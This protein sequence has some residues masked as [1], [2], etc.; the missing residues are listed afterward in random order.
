MRLTVKRLISLLL[1]LCLLVPVGT[2][3]AAEEFHLTYQ[4]DHGEI[5]VTGYVGSVPATLE[6]P[7][8]IEGFPVTAIALYAFEGCGSLNKVVLPA[9]LKRIEDGAFYDCSNLTRIILPESLSELGGLVFYGCSKLAVTVYDNGR[10]L[11]TAANP[12]YALINIVDPSVEEMTVHGDACLVSDSAF[13]FATS[14]KTIHV[15]EDSAHFSADDRGV[16]LNKDQT[17]VL[18]APQGLTGSYTLPE[19]VTAIGS[20]AFAGCVGL[21]QIHTGN[22]LTEI[23]A[24]A[25]GECAALELVEMGDRLQTIGQEAFYGCGALKELS[26][27]ASLEHLGKDAFLECGSL[28]YYLYSGGLY[29]GNDSNPYHVL[30]KAVDKEITSFTVHPA[31]KIIAPCAFFAC[32][33]LGKITVPQGVVTIG[34][35]AFDDCYALTRVTLPDSLRTVGRRAFSWCLKLKS[36]ELPS[37]VTALGEEAFASCTA[38]ET[39]TLPAAIGRVEAGTFRYCTALREV[40]LEEG[41]TA[42]G[43]EAFY[44][45]VALTTVH[46]ADTIT[47]IGIAAFS[48][49]GSLEAMTVPAG[50]AILPREV[51]RGC[52]SLTEVTVNGGVTAIGGEA[53]LGCTALKQLRFSSALTAIG[54]LAFGDC[55]A[56]TS[57]SFGGDAPKLG[58]EVFRGVKATV[59]YPS[60]TARWTLAIK[61][62]DNPALTWVEGHRF[63]QYQDNQDATCHQDGTQR[64]VCQCCGAESV[65][66]VPGTGGHRY[67]NGLCIRCGEEEPGLTGSAP[68]G[69]TV[70]LYSGTTLLCTLEA[71]DGSYTVP[72]LRTADYRLIAQHPDYVTR[73][74]ELTLHAGE[75]RLD[76]GLSP[77][78]DVTGDGRV[79]IMDMAKL[80][81]HVKGTALLTD[82]YAFRCGNLAADSVLNIRDAAKLYALVRGS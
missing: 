48:G 16:L 50:V 25:F 80:Y 31:A 18:C 67:E 37:G 6:I 21:T 23:G 60:A 4:W 35:E 36:L 56:L 53:F 10:Y 28:L 77:L 32:H 75:N 52:T 3:F 41:I 76:I 17:K 73:E 62:C 42:I 74:Y 55:T 38:L 15:A 49:C 43:A 72:C 29:L 47:W 13:Y 34:D 70:S 11:G 27:P 1:C 69:T 7:D 57:L 66:S 40:T 12:R 64:A 44:D 46:M 63:S 78:G 51:F 8:S 22:S 68:L 59:C 14:L 45:C 61:E 81:A 26:L 9:G 58:T 39:V 24:A 19:T 33:K 20:R 79:N 30:I 65:V 82:A 2:V 54:D 71:A 5:T